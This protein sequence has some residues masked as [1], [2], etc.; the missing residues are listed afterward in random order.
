MRRKNK[1]KRRKSTYLPQVGGRHRPY[2]YVEVQETFSWFVRK[3][4][5]HL[6]GGGGGGGCMGVRGESEARG[7]WFRYTVDG[8]CCMCA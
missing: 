4:R 5:D 8:R 1:N 6:K 7:E 3:W 2:L